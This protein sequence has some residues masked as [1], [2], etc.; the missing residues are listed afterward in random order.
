[1]R[2]ENG[3]L[4]DVGEVASI[5]EKA[6]VFLLGFANFSERLLVDTRSNRG[7]RPLVEVVPSLGS[8][9]E[10][11]FWLGQNRPTLG[12]PQ[13][14]S[15]INWPHSPA[16]LMESGI[17]ER[18]RDRV[19]AGADPTSAAACERAFERLTRLELKTMLD[20][21]NGDRHVTLWPRDPD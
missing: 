6:D 14:F 1:V 8:F 21:I 12:V 10:R 5:V 19:D 9:Q 7:T 16:F 20:A 13:A 4:I 3:I 18:V 17:W 2:S 11:I 15:F